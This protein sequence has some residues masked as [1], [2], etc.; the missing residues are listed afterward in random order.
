MAT[1]TLWSGTPAGLPG[2]SSSFGNPTS[3]GTLF[4][5]TAAGKQL[6][7]YQWYVA[8]ANQA[9]SAVPFACWH[10]TGA[11]QGTLV[12]GSTVTSGTL[13]IG[14]FNLIMLAVPVTLST[15][16]TY[17]AVAG[18]S[19]PGP[20]TEFYWKESIWGQAGIVNGPLT[21]WSDIA[22]NGGTNPDPHTSNQQGLFQQVSADPTA[23]FPTSPFNS[24]GFWIGPVI[25]DPP[26]PGASPGLLGSCFP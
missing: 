2:S 8:D 1:Y 22:G 5:V 23:A 3:C 7:G 14:A 11:G 25:Q 16:I 13:N 4:S 19:S 21:A 20:F 17:M 15:G 26:A 9:S 10:A 12:S 18:D 6:A 24:S